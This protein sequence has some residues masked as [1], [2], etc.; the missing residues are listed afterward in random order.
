MNGGMKSIAPVFARQAYLLCALTVLGLPAALFADDWIHWRGPE[1]TGVSREKNLPDRWSPDLES[2]NN[3]L[4]WK[5]PFGGRSTPLIMKGRAYLINHVGEGINEQE[6]VMCFDA[7]TGKVLWEHKFNVFLTDIVSVRLGWTN[8][9]GD[10][11]TGNI[12]SHGTQGLFYCF[13]RDGKILWSHSMT[14][15]YGRITGYGGRVTSPIVD[16]DLVIIGMLNASWGDQAR[17]GNRYVAFDKRTGAPV[18]WTST[19]FQPVDTYYSCP[20]IAVINGERLLISGGAEGGVHAFKV[21][22]GE[23]V[24]SYIFGTGAVNCSPVVEGTRVYIGHG[25]ENPDTNLQGRIVCIDAGKVKDGKP[26]LVW[27]VD[28]IKAKYTSPVVHEGRLYVTDEVGKLFCFDAATGGKGKPIWTFTYGRNS[29]GSPVL[30]DGKIYI[31][32]VNARFHIL[33]PTEKSCKRLHQQ[34]FRSGDPNSD[35]EINGSP[36]IANGRIYFTTGEEFYCIGKKDSK[37][38]SDPIPAVAEEAKPTG[39]AT[40]LQ[41]VPAD[42]SL[43]AGDSAEFKARSFDEHGRLVKEEKAQWSL[44]AAPPPPAAQNAPPPPKGAP[45]PTAPPVLQGDISAEGKLTL[46]KAPPVQFGLVVG[47]VGDLTA[48]ARIRVTPRLPYTM[49]L[50]PV[51]DGR[52]PAGWVN[53]QGKFAVQTMPDGTKILKK[54]A[55]VASPLV[56]RANAFIS[57]PSLTDYTIQSDVLGMKVRGDM[58]DLGIV[59][60]RYTLMLAGNSQKLRLISWDALPRVDKT[61]DWTWKPE[62]WYRMK[63]TVASK[64]GKA[65]I[66]GKVWPRDGKEPEAWTVEFED[67]TPNTEGSPAL[68]GYAT[69]I[70]ENSPGAEIYYANVSVTPN[71]SAK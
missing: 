65:L 1:Q 36:A 6:R 51:P 12:Y 46:A 32:D 61:I 19:G 16:G 2:P 70:L 60:N 71:G 64:G 5:V 69:G 68:Y 44:A 23:K 20:V 33:Q 62:T 25:E 31:A 15:E 67:P 18:W 13:N 48:S 39:K 10:P 28:G 53:T 43:E 58:P 50:T 47:K 63:L 35:I 8:L 59:A 54:T 37:A 56:A 30:A 45:T 41:I 27:K 26:E 22:T 55:V 66:R 17:G 29:K 52:T 49:N 57:K 3:N 24:W 21:R 14:E 42:I 7:D 9:A 40:I 11:E 4:I 34:F 38:T